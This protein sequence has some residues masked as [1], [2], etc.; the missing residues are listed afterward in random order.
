MADDV[1]RLRD[2]AMAAILRKIAELVPPV[3]PAGESEADSAEAMLPVIEGETILQLAEA[4][5]W[6]ERPDQTHGRR[7]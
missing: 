5:A 3:R 4:Y 2:E 1:S 7:P 6:L